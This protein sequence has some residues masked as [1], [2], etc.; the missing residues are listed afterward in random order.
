MFLLRPRS[1]NSG[2]PA[3]GDSAGRHASNPSRS[4]AR[5]GLQLLAME[6][7]MLFDG[8]GAVALDAAAGCA[9]ADAGPHGVSHHGF[10]RSEPAAAAAP[11]HQSPPVPQTAPACPPAPA[12][13]APDATDDLRWVAEDS[14][15]CD[16]QVLQGNAF[17]DHPDHDPD[18]DAIKV[19]GVAAGLGT[20]TSNHGAG[21]PVAGCYGTLLLQQDGSYCYT[22]AS[23]LALRAG[24]AVQDQFTYTVRD[25]RGAS[26]TAH[27][28]L[29]ICGVNSAPQAHDDSRGISTADVVTDG[30][31]I[32]GNASGD[33][34]DTDADGDC[35][36]V[37]GVTAGLTGQPLSGGVGSAVT[38]TY[39]TLVLCADGSY[40]YT[41]NDAGAALPSQQR[42]QDVFSYT[43]Q[44]TAGATSTAAITINL[45]GLNHAPTANADARSIDEN[46]RIT[47][48]QAIRGDTLGDQADTDIDGDALFVVGVGAGQAAGPL[49]G[50]V[51]QPIAGAHGTLLMG[52]DGAYSYTPDASS[53]A[54]R[55][56]ESFQD[57][58][59]YTICDGHGPVS[60]AT[61]TI[62]LTG[63]DG[64]LVANPDVRTTDQNTPIAGNAV[65]GGAPGEHADSDENG[66]VIHVQGV[67]TGTAGGPQ[68]GQVGTPVAGQYGTLTM[69]PDGSYLYTPNDTARALPAGQTADDQFSY[70]VNDGRGQTSTTTFT[71]HVVGLDDPPTANPDRNTIS[72][73][74][75]LPSTGN[76]IANGAPT[77]QRDTDTDAGD[78]L[79]V[80][81]A[82]PGGGA[83]PAN[84]PAGQ[85]MTGTFGN[86]TIDTSGAYRYVVDGTNTTVAALPAGQNLTDTFTYT[87]RDSGGATS[88]STVTITIAGGGGTGQNGS[89]TG[90]SGTGGTGAGGTGTGGTGTSGTGPVGGTPGTG[91]GNGGSG[92][93]GTGGGSG[94]SNPTG[95]GPSLPIVPAGF[96]GPVLGNA[97]L[98]QPSYSGISPRPGLDA[99]FVLPPDNFGPFVFQK[100]AGVVEE[101]PGRP[102]R[103]SSTSEKAADGASARDD[104]L[105]TVK[106]VARDVAP[107]RPKAVK[108]SVFA[109][110]LVDK[111]KNF[112]EQLKVARKAFRPPVKVAPERA[113]VKDC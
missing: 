54:L 29:V 80:T 90:G 2:K 111:P 44:D 21:V 104:C 52:A 48:G 69:Q 59:S 65:T 66:D 5:L 58:F 19:G 40:S 24:Q 3:S 1:K 8:A 39:G 78:V 98:P 63:V 102:N 7:R 10:Q 51:G 30:Q 96:F 99:G 83:T 26:D 113:R 95:S 101:A 53:A 109:K 47:D 43:I 25:S 18:G 4:P 50:A 61:I 45:I 62:T 68:T 85:T 22:P 57:T 55:A 107:V 64:R 72:N 16:G 76:V 106:T 92:G 71:V 81:G 97:P 37:R 110:P 73:T 103:A 60:T 36:T 108:P 105:D 42:A 67:G 14:S 91:D 15:I 49:E 23:D 82:H 56:G 32:A 35:L 28:T 33:N 89:G 100:V 94:P 17:G 70:T 79:T 34:R 41:P 27:L 112:S 93:S 20:G 11:A 31:A 84:T 12:N 74:A 38:G 6:P 77:D 75:T 87:I 9:P 46:G 13:R 88:S 86:L